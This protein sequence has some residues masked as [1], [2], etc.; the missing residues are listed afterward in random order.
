MP[1]REAGQA[2]G[3]RHHVEWTWKPAAVGVLTDH[4]ACEAALETLLEKIGWT[5]YQN[6]ERLRIMRFSY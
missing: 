3:Q 2:E 4:E 1:V 5:F 6:K